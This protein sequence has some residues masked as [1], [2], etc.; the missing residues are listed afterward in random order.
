MVRLKKLRT[1]ILG[2][3]SFCFWVRRCLLNK[4]VCDLYGNDI[5]GEFDRAWWALPVTRR[6]KV[7]GHR[8]CPREAKRRGEPR[9]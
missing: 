2:W 4:A 6:D 3:I 7:R 9:A 5:S 1:K 8:S